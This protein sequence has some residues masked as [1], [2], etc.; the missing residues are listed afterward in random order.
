[1][2]KPDP[3]LWKWTGKRF[4]YIGASRLKDRTYTVYA[5]PRLVVRFKT[6]REGMADLAVGDDL[7]DT[8]KAVVERRAIPYAISISPV[9]DTKQYVSSWKSSETHV[10]IAGLRRVACKLVN[11]SDHAAAVEWVNKR[12]NGHGYGVLRRTIAHL[13]STSPIGIERAA[14][15]ARAKETWNPDLHPRGPRGRF[16]PGARGANQIRRRAQRASEIRNPNT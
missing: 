15:K 10:V 13:N 5:S 3:T 16:A 12:G 4:K 6:D 11:I 14:R 7:R 9:G 2:A 8:T 1:M